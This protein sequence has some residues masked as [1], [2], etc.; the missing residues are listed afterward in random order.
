[1]SE[2][3]TIRVLRYDP[4]KDA[5]PRFE[6]FIVPY[7]DEWV[8]LDALAY[9]KEALDPSLAYRGSCHMAVCG[10]CGMM[11]NRQPK[12]ACHSFIR[13][14]RG[15]L[16]TVEPLDHF[17]IER[18]LIVDQDGF[19]E[20]L[21]SL[22]PYLVTEHDKP[23]S[24]GPNLQS[25]AELAA[26]RPF[27]QCINCLLCYA[28]CPQVAI[29]EAFVGPAALAIAHRYNRD[30]RDSGEELRSEVTDSH[31][32]VWDCTFV[33]AC[34]EVCPK[35]VDPAAAIQRTKISASFRWLKARLLPGGTS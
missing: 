24:E 22:Y 6:D 4:D 28:A 29:N 18:D 35:N 13:D 27:T 5:E 32:G 7:R 19:I 11:I 14:Y 8:V 10:S 12:L 23:L 20:K 1:M 9:I 3:I 17:P 31:H 21:T 15:Q 34:S 16:V 25:P 26:F 30:S 2:T 33:G